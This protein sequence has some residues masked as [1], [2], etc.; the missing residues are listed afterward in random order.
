MNI[1]KLVTKLFKCM[2]R[3]LFL[4]NGDSFAVGNKAGIG[5]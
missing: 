5:L 1:Y 4:R 2:T 3:N